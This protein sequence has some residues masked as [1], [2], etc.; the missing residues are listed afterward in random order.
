MKAGLTYQQ[1]Q[2]DNKQIFPTEFILDKTFKSLLPGAMFQ[3]K[4]SQKKNLRIFYRSY[5]TA[6]TI[7]Q[8]QS[9][10]DNSNPLQLTSGNPDLKQNWQNSVIMRYSEVN[11]EKSTSFFALFNGTFI[12]NYIAN[13]AIIAPYDTMLTQGIILA[14]GSQYLRP[15]NLNGYYNL[16]S[17]V[18]Y[19]FTIPKIKSNMNINV[20]G[21]YSCTPGLINYYLNDAY[22]YS[23]GLGL[24]LSSNVSEKVDFMVSSNTTYNN[25][26]SSLQQNLNSTYYNQSSKFKIQLMPWKGLVLETDLNHQYYYG[27]SQNKN[28]NYL[29]WNAAIG[30]KF[31]KNKAADIRLSVYDILKQNTSITRNTTDTYYEDVQTIVLQRYIMLTFTYNLKKYNNTDQSG[32]HQYQDYKGHDH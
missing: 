2:L 17:F 1:A 20:G 24:V 21:T 19:S 12:H 6:P 8:L 11:T 18:N 28:Q 22:N 10:I 15:V 9:V 31:L 26:V 14:S 30:Y 25:I 32:D 3:Y 7:T 16:S 4:F 27:L 29:L 23:A 13:S 5:N